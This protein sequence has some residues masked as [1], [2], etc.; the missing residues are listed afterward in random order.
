MKKQFMLLYGILGFQLIGLLC[1]YYYHDSGLSHPAVLL[2][3]QPVDP[4]DFLR[5]DYIILN[6]SIT[7]VP[8]NLKKQI[9]KSGTVYVTLKPEEDGPFHVIESIYSYHPRDGVYPVLKG[10]MKNGRIQYDL[11]KFFV[12]EGDGNPPLPITV[13]VAIDPD[14]IGRIKTLYADGAQWPR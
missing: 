5:G 3:T 13:E 14:G 11:E 10:R 7:Q 12:P 4:R 9:R 6:Y 1:L 8:E 2:E